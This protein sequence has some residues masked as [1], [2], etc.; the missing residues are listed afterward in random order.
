M[1]DWEQRYQQG[2]TGWDRGTASPAIE[3]WLSAVLKAPA[4]VLI[5]GCG[6]GH[7]A[8]FLASHG[9]DVTGIDIATSAV[10]HLEEQLAAE[11][12][13]AEVILGDLFAY[14]PDKPFDVVYEQTCLCAIQPHERPAYEAKLHSWLK[15]GGHL[16]ALFMQTGADGG[17][18]FHSDLL[19]MHKLFPD[20]RWQWLT[21]EPLFVPHRNGRFELGYQLIRR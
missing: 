11:G 15:P 19:A 7:E 16:L 8:V 13:K 21:E 17:P 9:F 10:L 4:R 5:P 12:L 14:Q 3:H 1:N 2:E 20:E 18:P 6:R